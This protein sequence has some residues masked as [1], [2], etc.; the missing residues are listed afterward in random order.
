MGDGTQYAEAT[1]AT[2]REMRDLRR[3]LEAEGWSVELGRSHYKCRHPN[4][5]MVIMSV[6][7]SCS[8]AAMNAR[9]DVRRLKR[10]HGEIA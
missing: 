4:G 1:M 9:A 6:T 10:Q 8:H 2:S 7:P 5:G 3:E